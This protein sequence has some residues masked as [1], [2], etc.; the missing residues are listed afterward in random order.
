MLTIVLPDIGA[1]FTVRANGEPLEIALAEDALQW[2]FPTLLDTEVF[3]V[4]LAHLVPAV[5]LPDLLLPARWASA[6]PPVESSL[7]V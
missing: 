7:A 1:D 5:L 2:A 4:F 6:A 3:P